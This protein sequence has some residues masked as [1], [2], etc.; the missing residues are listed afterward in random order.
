[1]KIT[2]NKNKEL[3]KE[4]RE[5]I[6]QNEGYCPCK[7]TKISENKCMC[8]EFLEQKSGECHCGLYVKE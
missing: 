3:V 7:L 6:K 1:M 2:V 8:T 5:K 4:V